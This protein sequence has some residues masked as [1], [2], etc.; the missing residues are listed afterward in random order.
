MIII[1]RATLHDQ[2]PNLYY[3]QWLREKAAVCGPEAPA[4][5]HNE[6]AASARFVPF[7][8]PDRDF[9]GNRSPLRWKFPCRPK[10]KS[11][12]WRSGALPETARP[13]TASL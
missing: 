11:A 1:M 5:A 8:V 2:A 7:D 9:P 10:R 13:L 12:H 4:I 3:G 6:P